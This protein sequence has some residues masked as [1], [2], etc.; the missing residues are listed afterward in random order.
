[1]KQLGLLVTQPTASNARRLAN[2]STAKFHKQKFG[3]KNS[4]RKASQHQKLKG[5]HA[6][7]GLMLTWC[8]ATWQQ[9]LKQLHGHHHRVIRHR[10]WHVSLLIC[11]QQYHRIAC[12][13][14]V[15]RAAL[16]TL[17][18]NVLPS[19]SAS[20]AASAAGCMLA[21]RESSRPQATSG[22]TR[23]AVTN[24]Q[25]YFRNSRLNIIS[26][27]TAALCSYNADSHHCVR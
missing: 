26:N 17:R 8:S 19:P 7:A 27:S 12:S 23:N 3:Y 2:R 5:T 16:R 25:T 22:K 15:P 9:H 18:C 6:V 1:V 24:H 11:H 14:V 20:H 21:R 4:N 13:Y 10:G